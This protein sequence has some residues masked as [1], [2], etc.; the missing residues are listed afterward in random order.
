MST[1]INRNTLE[2]RERVSTP[3]YTVGH[4]EAN[5][6]AADWILSPDLT[7]VAGLEQKYWKLTGDIFSAMTA[8]ERTAVDDSVPYLNPLKAKRYGEIDLKT[9]ALIAVG[10]TYD[11]NQFSLSLPAQHNWHGLLMAADKTWVTFPFVI[12]TID[13]NE[14]TLPTVAACN[15]FVRDGFDVVKG[16]LESGRSLKKQVFDATTKAAVDAVVDNRT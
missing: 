13:N 6:D 9:Q 11:S 4:P 16:H 1:A 10:F 7:P 8:G 2:Y 15:Q 12:S 5:P 14:Y 3:R